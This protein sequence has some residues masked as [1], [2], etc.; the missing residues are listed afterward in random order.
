MEQAVG[1]SLVFETYDPTR[2]HQVLAAA[3]RLRDD[4]HSEPA[5]RLAAERQLDALTAERAGVLLAQLP[6]EALKT[7]TNERLRFSGLDQVRVNTVAD[8]R[9]PGRSADPGPG[10]R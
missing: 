6:V 2:L 3:R 9:R 10:H 4:P 1:S 8:A 7:A 5:L